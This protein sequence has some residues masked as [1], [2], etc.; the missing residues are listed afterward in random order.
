MK[1]RHSHETLDVIGKFKYFGHIM[2]TSDLLDKDLVRGWKTV[3]DKHS[4]EEGQ[5][6]YEEPCQTGMTP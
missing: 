5:M 2:R 3:I 6:K 1:P 4:G